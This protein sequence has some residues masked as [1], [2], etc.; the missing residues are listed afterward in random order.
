VYFQWGFT[1]GYGNFSPTNIIGT[2]LNADLPVAIPVGPTV[3][4]QTYHYRAV[5]INTSGVMWGADYVVDVRPSATIVPNGDGTLTLS[6]LAIMDRTH[7]LWG[8]TNLGP[9]AVWQPIATG[10]LGL[11][12][13]WEFTDTTSPTPPKLY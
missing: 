9:S 3:L 1:S 10:I 4:G 6:G 12:G 7:T 5:A 11:D 2:N 8:T 13:T